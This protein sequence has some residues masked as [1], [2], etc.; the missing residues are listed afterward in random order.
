MAF[1]SYYLKPLYGNSLVR[2]SHIII[3]EI[4]RS[5]YTISYKHVYN[6]SS[7]VPKL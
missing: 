3:P 6:D 7:Y 4:E 5:N 1:E 2:S